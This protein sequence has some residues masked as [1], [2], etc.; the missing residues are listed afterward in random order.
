MPMA[1]PKSLVKKGSITELMSQLDKHQKLDIIKRE[2]KIREPS[3]ELHL[4][5][6]YR[7]VK[8]VVRLVRRIKKRKKLTDKSAFSRWK[9]ASLDEFLLA[10]HD[11]RTAILLSK[12]F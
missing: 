11:F 8:K 7:G 12:A 5:L 9:F 6:I 4:K 1:H 2:L 10:A 3:E